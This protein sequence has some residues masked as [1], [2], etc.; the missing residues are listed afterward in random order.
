MLAHA[1]EV[2]A[3]TEIVFNHKTLK[4]LKPPSH[5]YPGYNLIPSV[6]RILLYAFNEQ[7]SELAAEFPRMYQY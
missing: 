7:I 1:K 6:H 3:L 5:D 4:V 2:M